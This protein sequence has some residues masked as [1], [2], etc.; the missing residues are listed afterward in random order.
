MKIYFISK[1]ANWQKYRLDVL[2]KLG[3]NY[4][5]SIEILT[6]GKIK[7]YLSDRSSVKYKSFSSIIPSRLKISF[8]P[9]ILWYIVKNKPEV[10]LAINNTTYLTEYC[11]LILCRILKIKFIWWTHAYDHKKKSNVF[12]SKIREKYILFFLKKSNSIITFSQKGHD[13]LV[14]KGIS[15]QKIIVAKNTLDTDSV[16]ETKNQFLSKKEEIKLKF[17]FKP[18]DKI[19]I[20]TGRLTKDKKVDHAIRA[21]HEL[22]TDFEDNLK[23]VVIGDGDE[24]KS[25]NELTTKLNLKNIYF[26]GE[27]YDETILAQWLLISDLYI[28]P[29]YVGLGIIHAFCYG[30]PFITEEDENHGPEIQYLKNG[31]NGYIV[32]KND[33]TELKNR[34]KELIS[35]S[36]KLKEFSKQAYNTVLNEGSIQLMVENMNKSISAL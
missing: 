20:F 18:T 24:F 32:G 34:I 26:L 23:L 15:A 3:D 6:T 5:H 25:L 21:V 14:S 28:M 10:V 22:M 16:F 1:D 30:L 7:E 11:S 19:L 31:I 27:I 12:L 17:G 2:S 8:M 29:S 13:Y 36:E 35:N 9:G 4:N 33:I